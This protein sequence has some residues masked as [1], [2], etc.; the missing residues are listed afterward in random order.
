MVQW[1]KAQIRNTI[2]IIS[3][4]P[5]NFVT[6]RLKTGQQWALQN[7]PLQGDSFISDFLMQAMGFSVSSCESDSGGWLR[8]LG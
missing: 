3:E 8:R 6:G 1:I 4:D 5:I 2:A 7:R